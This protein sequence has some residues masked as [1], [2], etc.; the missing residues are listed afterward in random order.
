VTAA[1]RRLARD[2]SIWE[3]GKPINRVQRGEGVYVYHSDLCRR[4]R[5]ATEVIDLGGRRIGNPAG[6]RTA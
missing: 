3:L 1:R 5:S 2:S 4:C 6:S